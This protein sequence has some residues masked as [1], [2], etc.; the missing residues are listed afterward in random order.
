[1]KCEKSRVIVTG[2]LPGYWGLEKIELEELALDIE[3]GEK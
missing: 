1:M 2:V 3:A